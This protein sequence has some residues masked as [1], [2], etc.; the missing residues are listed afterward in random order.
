MTVDRGASALTK[1][2]CKLAAEGLS[3]EQIC[4]AFPDVCLT[5]EAV[6]IAIRS[7]TT[8]KR[9]NI[10]ELIE[11]HRGAM[12][13]VLASIAQDETKNESARVKAATVL[14][15]RKGCLPLIEADEVSKMFQ[16]MQELRKEN[17]G[18]VLEF[19]ASATKVA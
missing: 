15:E 13:E 19:P 12:V 6:S 16:R 11:S 7:A 17:D 18:K 9:I 2:I 10:D 8:T 4:E 1:Q 5:P 14:V 3:P